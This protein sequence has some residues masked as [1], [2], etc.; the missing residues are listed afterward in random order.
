MIEKKTYQ[1]LLSVI[2]DTAAKH[3]AES[4]ETYY[5]NDG[6]H[7]VG[8]FAQECESMCSDY[9]AA[10]E[11]F[12]GSVEC[13]DRTGGM[14]RGSDWSRV[15]HFKDHDVYIRVSGGYYSH[16]G[17]YFGT[18]EESVEEV[19]PEEKTITVYKRRK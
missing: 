3:I 9:D 19:L 12:F 14:D 8:Y 16:D 10:N 5:C 13:V 2:K 15:Y 11:P 6:Y 1:E 17:C 4:G 18:W 7:D